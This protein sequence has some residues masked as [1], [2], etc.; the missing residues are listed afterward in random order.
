MCEHASTL[1]YNDGA[2]ITV[3]ERTVTDRASS[4]THRLL[5]VLEQLVVLPG[6][7]GH[8]DELQ[9]VAAIVA[10]Q[11]RA[12]GLKV[13]QIATAG[14]PLIVGRRAGRSAFTMLLYHH[15]DV[16]PTGPWRAWD[17]DPCRVSERDGLI[18][19]RGVADGKGPLAAHLDAISGL[20][21]RDGEL[22]CGVV[23]VAEGD[24]LIGSPFLGQA[25]VD[26]RDVLRGDACLATGGGRD[27]AGRP[28]C[29]SGTKGL[30]QLRLRAE[31]A[32]HA[33]QSGLAT[34]VPNPLW[35]LIWALSQIKSDQEEI[36][37][38]GF[39]DTIDGPERS[40]TRALRA[41]AIDDNGR[42]AAWKLDQLLF[43]MSGAAVMQAEVTLPTCNV[44]LVQV[45]PV[46][47][48]ALVPTAASARLDFQLVPRQHPQAVHD[49]LCAHLDAKDLDDIVVTRLPGG[50][51]SASTPFEHEFVQRV[52]AA[53]APIVGAPLT[54]LPRGP[55]AL[56]LTFFEQAFGMPIAVVGCGRADSGPLAPNEHIPLADL[57]A[58]S[59]LAAELL[60]ACGA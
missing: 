53:A 39:Y 7:P 46:G 15:Y 29:Y 23:V 14:A 19:G 11:M 33:L 18:Y 13:E 37:I 47:E 60:R 43:G 16:A 17:Q 36:L 21:E 38:D 5:D 54:V 45:E 41:A 44:S 58:H 48:L 20:L 50:Y 51:S 56:P 49:L 8:P 2:F 30:L 34:S 6:S 40:E 57:E 25:I 55:V 35:R 24:A 52:S 9:S 3:S 27:A 26:H 22:P 4:S 1:C 42:L 32:G 59:R 28:F 31:G 12:S 10:S